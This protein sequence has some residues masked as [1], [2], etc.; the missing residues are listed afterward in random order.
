MAEQIRRVPVWS[1]W[2]RVAHWA[3]AGATLLMLV[4]GWLIANA[5]T[6]AAGAAEVHYLGAAVLVFGLA[7]RLFLG[8]AGK[9]AERLEHLVPKPSEMTGLRNSALFYLSLGK[10]PLPNW[11]AHNPLWKPIYLVWFALL[12][13][14]ALTG[15]LMPDTP[16]VGVF[17]LPRV[18][19]WMANAVF[20][21]TLA[22]VY[23]VVLQD[24]RGQA[25]D[26]SAMINGHR[27]F[28]VEREGLV[29]P[30]VPQVS[31]RIDDLNRK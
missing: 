6:V 15:W 3:L 7:L 23:S 13:L 8:F 25:A 12:A 19:Q 16:V 17:Y 30:E 14:S 5:P 28:R 10:A 26:T 2:L 21:V 24:L 18:H 11:Y 1:G 9:G 29:K 4:T 31:I 20:V 27:Y 22:H